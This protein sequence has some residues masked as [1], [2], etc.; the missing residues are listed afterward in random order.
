VAAQIVHDDDIARRKCWNEELFDIGEEA[1]PIDGTVDDAGRL[2][3]VASERCEEGEG[4]PVSMRNLGDEPLAASAAPMGARHIG[5]GPG[6]VEED[7]AGG[8][9]L[10]LVAPPALAPS[11]NVRPVLL[12]CVQAFF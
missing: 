6:L 8:V 4:S 9:E 12:A 1:S 5:F 10:A 11:V 3:P 7:Q 2:D